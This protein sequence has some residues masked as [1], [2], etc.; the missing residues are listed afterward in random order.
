MRKLA[1]ITEVILCSSTEAT[2]QL[3]WIWKLQRSFTLAQVTWQMLLCCQDL[4]WNTN[5]AAR[6]SI[7]FRFSC[8]LTFYSYIIFLLPFLVNQLMTPIL[9]SAFT[10]AKNS[11]ITYFHVLKCESS[12]NTERRLDS[13]RDNFIYNISSVTEKATSGTRTWNFSVRRLQM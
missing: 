4:G 12:C 5:S 2:L 7:T 11:K 6:F 9:K 13:L 8:S 10:I 3:Y 1:S